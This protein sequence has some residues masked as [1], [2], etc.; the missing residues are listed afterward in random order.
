MNLK[1][2]TSTQLEQLAKNSLDKLEALEKQHTK[3]K[4]V[5]VKTFAE[6]QKLTMS[7]Q[8]RLSDVSLREVATIATLSLLLPEFSA[9]F[10]QAYKH[11]KT[12]LAA[13]ERAEGEKI[14]QL[15]EKFLGEILLKVKNCDSGLP[16]LS[17]YARTTISKR[18]SSGTLDGP[19]RSSELGMQFAPLAPAR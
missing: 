14:H 9:K 17:K 18:P 7:L 3:R 1:N 4:L 16:L 6:I 8:Q 19:T 10:E 11:P 5:L 12:D 13:T 15:I 2:M